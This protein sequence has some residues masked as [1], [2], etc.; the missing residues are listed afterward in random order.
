MQRVY[1][2]FQLRGH[3]DKICPQM[4]YR[5]AKAMSNFMGK[6]QHGHL[7]WDTRAI[8]WKCNYSSVQT[9]INFVAIFCVRFKF[10]TYA[11]SRS[12]QNKQSSAKP[13]A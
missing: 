13:I 9:F 5:R 11:A 8:I 6:C 3:G 7:R 4:S 12:C 1:K 2:T 10:L